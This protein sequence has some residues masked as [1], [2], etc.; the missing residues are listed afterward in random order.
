M[1]DQAQP[2]ISK[3]PDS[4]E[5][6]A[7]CKEFSYFGKCEVKLVRTRN[8]DGSLGCWCEPRVT[9]E[10]SRTGRDV[11]IAGAAP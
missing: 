4:V 9:L 11:I 5:S 1:L 10:N 8:G 2:H 6:V 7:L 3:L